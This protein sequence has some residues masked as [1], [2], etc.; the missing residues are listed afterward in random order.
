MSVKDFFKLDWK[1]FVLF[2]VFNLLATIGLLSG[3][4][5]A[6]KHMGFGPFDIFSI[7]GQFTCSGINPGMICVFDDA[8]IVIAAVLNLAWQFFLACLVMFA[9][10]KIRK[11]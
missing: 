10:K 2:V 9:V 6:G 1:V 8:I 5:V 7:L 4:S 3:G 11:Q